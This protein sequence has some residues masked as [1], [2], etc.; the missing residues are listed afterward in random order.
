MEEHEKASEHRSAPTQNISS[1]LLTAWWAPYLTRSPRWERRG[2]WSHG[3]QEPGDVSCEGDRPA[4]RALGEAHD[5]QE[6]QG[7][8]GEGGLKRAHQAGASSLPPL[9]PSVPFD[10]CHLPLI[11][12]HLPA[13]TDHLPLTTYRLPSG[14][15][16][17]LSSVAVTETDR[18]CDGTAWYVGS[19]KAPQRARKAG[20]RVS[21]W[22]YR[23]GAHTARTKVLYGTAVCTWY[24][25]VVLV[26][27]L[28]LLNRPR[29]L[30]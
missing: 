15:R 20:P 6:A 5:A 11:T 1:C 3:H 19:I 24:D 8:R 22:D 7:G 12:Y 27:V 9:C 16:R 10:T 17:T 26:L 29:R 25:V 23:Q 21:R 30:L 14:S 18:P 13:N 2:Q 28:V 4:C